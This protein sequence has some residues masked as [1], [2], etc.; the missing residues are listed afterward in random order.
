MELLQVLSE[1]GDACLL[2]ETVFVEGVTW[3]GGSR[4]NGEGGR[5]GGE[6]RGGERK[7]RWK[8][9]EEG[10]WKRW[11]GERKRVG[12][13]S[14]TQLV[15]H[16]NNYDATRCISKSW[17]HHSRMP[18]LQTAGRTLISAATHP[19]QYLN[20]QATNS[21]RHQEVVVLPSPRLPLTASCCRNT[22]RS[23]DNTGERRHSFRDPRGSR[24]AMVSSWIML[25]S[26][27]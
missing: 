14:Q 18:R 9:G 2:W 26:N 8:K 25:T 3:N 5:G 20:S 22:P 4:R 27:H 23:A 7:E 19:G 6:E 16:F 1:A 17:A 21:G 10:E 13:R 24:E 12:G 15:P 11:G